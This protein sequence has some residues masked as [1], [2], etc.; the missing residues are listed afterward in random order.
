ML[1]LYFSVIVAAL[2]LLYIFGILS[3]IA[4]VY[5]VYTVA[6]TN[7]THTQEQISNKTT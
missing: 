2:L 5:T 7:W 4:Y 6:Y 3:H 1:P